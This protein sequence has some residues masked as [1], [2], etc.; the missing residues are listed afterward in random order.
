MP[1]D[2]GLYLWELFTDDDTITTLFTWFVLG[3]F[4]M[5]LFVM[6]RWQEEEMA[7]ARE[8]EATR[9]VKP[10]PAETLRKAA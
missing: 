2:F 9:A 1:A 7:R 6:P 5:A 3:G 4:S 10:A 8:E